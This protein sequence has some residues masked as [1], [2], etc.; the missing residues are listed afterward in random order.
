MTLRF[1]LQPASLQR[2]E[3][4]L[5]E[6]GT[7]AADETSERAARVAVRL[8]E[9]NYPKVLE[10]RGMVGKP[11]VGTVKPRDIVKIKDA[12]VGRA[13]KT[14]NGWVASFEMRDDL[15]DLSEAKVRTVF[16]KG[17]SKRHDIYP[18]KATWLTGWT[19]PNTGR[20]ARA[21]K[22][23]HPGSQGQFDTLRLL[24]DRVYQRIRRG[25]V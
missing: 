15:S 5:I 16:M 25:S 9:E 18:V 1:E 19:D 7:A 2:L 20:Q 8:F 14:A 6:R 11:N 3:R 24:R 12:M 10:S 21:K 23:D 13:R 17:H 4:V 22:V